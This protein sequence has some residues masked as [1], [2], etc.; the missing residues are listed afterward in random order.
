MTGRKIDNI[1]IKGAVI[2]IRNVRLHVHLKNFA[3][4]LFIVFQLSETLFQLLV[5]REICHSLVVLFVCKQN[6]AVK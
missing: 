2:Q 1:T 6:A 3:F 4:Q 5:Y